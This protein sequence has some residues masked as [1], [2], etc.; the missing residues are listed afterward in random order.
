MSDNM[1]ATSPLMEEIKEYLI[2]AYNE[3]DGLDKQRIRHLLNNKAITLCK[4][5]R[6]NHKFEPQEGFKSG[7][8]MYDLNP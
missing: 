6:C 3:A 7:L 1:E 5:P 8:L 4:C 2:N